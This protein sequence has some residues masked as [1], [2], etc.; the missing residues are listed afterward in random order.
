MLSEQVGGGAEGR[1]FGEVQAPLHSFVSSLYFEHKKRLRKGEA[2]VDAYQQLA[3]KLRYADDFVAYLRFATTLPTSHTDTR[4]L[5][6]HIFTEFER[7]VGSQQD[8]L[9][10]LQAGFE[11]LEEE[12][13]LMVRLFTVQTFHNCFKAARIDFAA[14]VVA[15]AEALK[16]RPYRR[17]LAV[18]LESDKTIAQLGLADLLSKNK[19]RSDY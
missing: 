12:E 2:V 13:Q 14:P 16:A 4:E 10:I 17:L 3:G 18:A 15:A 8:K 5:Q 6:L 11:A 19:F 7:L 1:F 9:S